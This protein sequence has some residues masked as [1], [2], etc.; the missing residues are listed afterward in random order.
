[1]GSCPLPSLS[2]RH[3]GRKILLSAVVLGSRNPADLTHV[4]VTALLD[5]GA[6]CSAISP[7]II[8]QLELKPYQRRHLRVATED[9]LVEY[10]FFRVGLFPD[11]SDT[12]L[13]R[14]GL[15]FVFAE[16]DGFGMRESMDFGLI[17]GMDVL[18]QCDLDLDRTGHW[19]LT[20]G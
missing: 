12:V 13:Q 5:T 11:E 6:T 3:D 14:D 16:V 17:I 10:Y 7:A 19:R 8:R 1:L 18:S 15:P 9:R 4:V 2:G 20:F